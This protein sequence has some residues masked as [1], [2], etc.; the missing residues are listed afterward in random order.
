MKG[1]CYLNGTE[2]IKQHYSRSNGT[3]IYNPTKLLLVVKLKADDA[4]N[5]SGKK[6]QLQEQCIKCRISTTVEET[7]AT[8]GWKDNPRGA[9]Q[10]LYERGW[11]DHYNINWYTA[12]GTILR[13]KVEYIIQNFMKMQQDFIEEMLCSSTVLQ[14]SEHCLIKLQSVNQKLL[15]RELSVPGQ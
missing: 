3:K 12:K 9:L 2:K 15:D 11:V 13:E 1:P 10:V 6:K 7:D 14:N 5:P 8:K 4:L